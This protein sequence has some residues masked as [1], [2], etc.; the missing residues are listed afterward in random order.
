MRIG[1]SLLLSICLCSIGATQPEFR[2]RAEGLGIIHSY[3]TGAPGGGISFVDFDGDGWDDLTLGSDGNGLI[4]FYQNNQGS[5]IRLPALVT[6]RCEQKQILWADYD[7]DGDKDLLVTCYGDVNRLY[8]NNGDL[9]LIDVTVAANLPLE[10][11]LTYGANFADVNR[12][13][14]LDIYYV[15]RRGPD[16]ADENRNRLFLN[17]SDGTFKEIGEEAGASD[18][19]KKPFCSTFFDYDNDRWPDL[20]IANDKLTT[21]TLL[22]NIKGRGFQDVSSGSQTNHSMNAM[23]VTIGDY[24]N[25]GWQDIFVTN[26]QEGSRF[27]R[28]QG[29][30]TNR[31]VFFE[32]IA[33]EINVQF[34]N[35]IGWGSVFLDA[36]NDGDLDLYVSGSLVGA[37]QVSAAFYENLDGR[38]F[39]SQPSSFAADTVLSYS[40]ASGDL[41]ND[42]LPD[43]IVS[44]HAPFQSHLWV[45]TSRSGKWIKVKLEGVV[46]NRDAVGAK[47]ELYDGPHY[48]MRYRHCG[49]GFLGQN[50]NSEIFGIGN[51]GIIDSLVIT[52]PSGHEDKFTDV[53]ANQTVHVMEG[54]TTEGIINIDP[55]IDDITSSV[56]LNKVLLWSLSPNPV[57][58]SIKID[59][60]LKAEGCVQVF[61]VNGQECIQKICRLQQSTELALNH[62]PPGVYFLRYQATDLKQ[63]GSIRFVKL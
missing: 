59:F 47:L 40:N 41:N 21:N 42:G 55:D 6:N 7:N 25:D 43:I 37:D 48:Q 60:T 54:S 26:T 53:T 4:H 44:N 23:C 12:D 14:W 16:A 27:F 5:F 24:N 28:N 3:G 52:W 15:E 33:E 8:A 10:Q 11:F 63:A 19:M 58:N 46:S 17:K 51:A 35:G 49:S 62:L 2:E 32:E 31:D 13:G 29:S 20:Y 38:I 30:M 45:N 34:S 57:Q 50:S 61:D 9:E 1:A 39:H 18:P 22:R 56:Q 36:D